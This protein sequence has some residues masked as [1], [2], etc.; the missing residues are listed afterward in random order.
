[1]KCEMDL[2]NLSFYLL[3]KVVVTF[4]NGQ[5]VCG[6]LKNVLI[7]SQE[8][9]IDD[10]TYSTCTISDIEMTGSITY[11][12][13]AKEPQKACEIDGLYFGL[14][15][16]VPD[17][18]YS[19]I[20]YGEFNCVAACHLVFSESKLSARDVRILS[21][22]HKVYL[23]AL[24]KASY[25]Y[26]LHDG[27][28]LVG[29]LENDAVLSIRTSSGLVTPIDLEQVQEIIRLP[30]TNEYVD[31]TLR[32]G[33]VLSGVVSA[34]NDAMI[35]VI[36]ETIQPVQLVDVLLLRYKDRKSVV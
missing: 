1:M 24:S 4:L 11:H 5:S 2:Y 36:G 32:N 27:S 34:A 9:L 35:V 22:S 15:D 12:T 23:P 26:L 31:I 20:L 25:L 8:I 14:D 30:M 33:S 29:T 7:A 21:F 16:F 6:I 10:L 19:R 17:T 3:K 28:I 13:Y 18:D